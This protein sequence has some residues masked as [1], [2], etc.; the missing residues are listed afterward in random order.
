MILIC[1]RLHH[2]RNDVAEVL[3]LA[4]DL[5]LNDKLL[6]SLIHDVHAELEQVDIGDIQGLRLR[7]LRI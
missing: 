6:D 2:K 5:S 4:A 1:G 3:T 7:S